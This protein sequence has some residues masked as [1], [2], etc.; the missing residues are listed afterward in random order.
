M[1]MFW[2]PFSN[3]YYQNHYQCVA[4][5]HKKHCI[6]T[7]LWLHWT[8][9]NSRFSVPI[10]RLYT[11]GCTNVPGVQPVHSDHLFFLQH[12]Q[13]SALQSWILSIT[14]QNGQTSKYVWYTCSDTL[15]LS[16]AH[17]APFIPF[18]LWKKK[19]GW[20]VSSMIKSMKYGHMHVWNPL[21]HSAYQPSH[22]F[23][24]QK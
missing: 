11:L 15:F 1:H 14:T 7:Q 24:R 2:A 9:I 8:S 23:N 13:V 10:Q 6:S 22:E 18:T 3:S 19:K 12:T 5:L 21:K 17:F 4:F 16:I 20:F